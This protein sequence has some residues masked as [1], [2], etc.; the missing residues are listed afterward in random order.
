VVVA[1]V[2]DGVVGTG[3]VV[4]GA[5]RV[6][7]RSSLPHPLAASPTARAITPSVPTQVPMVLFASVHRS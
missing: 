2:V 6:E 5:P 3:V 7:V 1:A 4:A